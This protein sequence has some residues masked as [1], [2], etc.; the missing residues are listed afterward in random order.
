MRIWSRAHSASNTSPGLT[1]DLTRDLGRFPCK[2]VPV[3][4]ARLIAA[5]S[6][7]V[8]RWTVS[9]LEDPLRVAPAHGEVEDAAASDGGELVPVPDERDPGA[10][11]VRDRQQCAGGVLV[12]HSCLVDQQQVTAV[13]YGLGCR[14]RGDPGPPAVSSHRNPY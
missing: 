12:E 5:Y 11:L 8:N 14:I 13:E 4:I 7:S 3:R 10:S 9:S 2:L 6:G 1:T